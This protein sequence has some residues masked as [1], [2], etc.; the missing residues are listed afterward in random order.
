MSAIGGTEFGRCGEVGH[1]IGVRCTSSCYDDPKSNDTRGYSGGG[2]STFY[3]P[4]LYQAEVRRAWMAAAKEKGTLPP[5]NFWNSS[6]R[7]CE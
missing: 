1:E 2:F 3:A 5:P 6:G 4:P 7:G